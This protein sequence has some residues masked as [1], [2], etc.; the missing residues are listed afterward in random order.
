MPAKEKIG[1]HQK[2][3]TIN[4]DAA[5]FG[6]FAEIGAGQEVAR[7]F[8]TVGG[9]SGTVA[10]T[11]SAYDKE[12]SDDL[13][14]PGTRYVSRPRLEAM[15]ESEWK[16]LLAEL[17]ASRGA[18]T[19]FF[20]YVDTISARNFAGT[21][22]CHGWVG[23]RFQHAPGGPPND[24]ILHI[25]LQDP[26]NLQQQEAVG[27]L[28]VNLIYAAC[29]SMDSPNSF[30]AGLFEDLSLSR[31]EIDLVDLKGPA[32]ESWDKRQLQ[33]SLVTSGYAEA[34]AFSA[35]GTAVPPTELLYKKALVLAPGLFE[36]VSDLH[37]QL[38]Q[39][40]LAQIPEAE[41]AQSKGGLGLFCLASQPLIPGNPAPT[42]EHLMRHVNDLKNL[43]FGTLIFRAKE[44]YTMSAYISR[45]TKSQVYFAV[46]LSVVVYAM[47]DRYN[48]LD[49]ALLEGTARLFSQNVKL[50]VY[51]M[52]EVALKERLAALGASGWSYETTKGLVYVNNLHPAEPINFLFKY[53][54]GCGFLVSARPAA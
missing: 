10:K 45:Y 16:Q 47:H 51:P 28:G 11:I 42:A 12:V 49:G 36:N 43:G 14:G 22:E 1:T 8:L 18:K 50:S 37:G 5:V 32:F 13:Y 7:W 39:S 27:I 54:L 26:S 30:L 3:L 9:A 29:H 6:S 52:T 46:G 40:T 24:V 15:M 44:L 53:L 23:L 2:A 41:L 25:N 38:I 20:A 34:V 4:L 33:A 21:N 48:N 31:L 35:E 17:Q 19:R